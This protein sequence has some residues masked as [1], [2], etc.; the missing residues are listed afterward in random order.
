MPGTEAP[1]TRGKENTSFKPEKCGSSAHGSVLP[2]PP[3][4]FTAGVGAAL[5]EEISDPLGEEV[6]GDDGKAGTPGKE[7]ISPA[8]GICGALAQGP[9]FCVSTDGDEVGSPCGLAATEWGT[10]EVAPESEAA[11]ARKS[12]SLKTPD[13]GDGA[14]EITLGLGTAGR[15]KVSRGKS[16]VPICDGRCPPVSSGETWG[17]IDNVGG[18]SGTPPPGNAAKNSFASFAIIAGSGTADINAETSGYFLAATA[19]S[20]AS[21]GVGKDVDESVAMRSLVLVVLIDID[22]LQHADRIFR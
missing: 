18:S 15:E 16:G 19:P 21:V 22:A 5:A 2:V 7:Y 11:M 10:S 20:C 6:G 13:D 3:E 8:G 17:E 14:L 1:G 12:A 4:S 9:P